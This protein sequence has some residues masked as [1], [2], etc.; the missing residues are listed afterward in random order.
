MKTT[1]PWNKGVAVGQKAPLKHYQ[2]W[3][4]RRLLETE[5]K[6]RDLA[7][8]FLALD[9]ML[10]SSDILRLKVGDI[11]GTHLK[12]KARLRICSPDAASHTAR[13]CLLSVTDSS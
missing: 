4:I 10:R 6:L 12:P 2:V 7:L 5:G 11:C 13:G 1:M 8:F 9:S 3:R